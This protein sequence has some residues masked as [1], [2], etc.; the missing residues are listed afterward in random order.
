MQTLISL[1]KLN[2]KASLAR[3]FARLTKRIPDQDT[4][5]PQEKLS[6]RSVTQK[7][8]AVIALMQTLKKLMIKPQNSGF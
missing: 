7:R 5:L 6:S 8:G 1:L 4:Q 3:A 2:H